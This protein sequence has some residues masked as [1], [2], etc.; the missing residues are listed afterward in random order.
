MEGCDAAVLFC[1]KLKCD[2]SQLT[3]AVLITVVIQNNF[4]WSLSCMAHIMEKS[5]PALHGQPELLQ[6]P[7][8][9][10]TLLTV[11]DQHKVTP[12]IAIIIINSWYNYT[13]MCNNNYSCDTSKFELTVSTVYKW[14]ISLAFVITICLGTLIILQVGMETFKES[15][16]IFLIFTL[17][18]HLHLSAL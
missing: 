3:S 9:V 4:E 5:C 14:L 13:S 7:Q 8:D 17:H 10:V 2:M 16:S 11:L 12:C 6:T 18:L 1:Y 15:I